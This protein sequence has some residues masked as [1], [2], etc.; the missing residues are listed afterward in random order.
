MWM[1]FAGESDSVFFYNFQTRQRARELPGQ[2]GD[3]VSQKRKA[4]QNT[5][6]AKIREQKAKSDR[7]A[8]S[9]H[10]PAPNQRDMAQLRKDVALG[11]PIKKGRAASKESETAK[12][13]EVKPVPPPPT[14]AMRAAAKQKA[15]EL[16]SSSLTYRHVSLQLR[17]RSLP[18]VLVAAGRFDV[19]VFSQPAML[20][21]V[22]AVVASDYLPVAWGKVTKQ[23]WNPARF[24]EKAALSKLTANERL[25]FMTFGEVPRYYN[26]L[27]R[28]SS[29]QHPMVSAVKDAERLMAAANP[30]RGRQDVRTRAENYR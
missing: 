26:S 1:L 25:R 10:A 6:E 9:K 21:L 12:K 29:D 7:L 14:A 28:L 11:R 3:E 8:Q 18:E 20:W 5:T 15:A 27:L 4:E 17:P 24:E 2:F 22:D 16:T 30:N 13:E 23:N 19:D